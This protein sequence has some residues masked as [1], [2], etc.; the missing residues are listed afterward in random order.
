MGARLGLLASGVARDADRTTAPIADRARRP[1]APTPDGPRTNG[2]ALVA[3]A[4]AGQVANALVRGGAY[5][6]GRDGVL[7]IVPGT[8]GIA[9]NKRIGDRAI[10]LVADHVEPGV[11]SATTIAKRAATPARRTAGSC[12][13]RAWATWHAS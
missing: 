11:P 13:I 2:D 6:I 8:G 4:V 5:R 9:L 12:S 10:G 7:R 3:L 1:A